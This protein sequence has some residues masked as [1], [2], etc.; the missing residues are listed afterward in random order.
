MTSPSVRDSVICGLKITHDG[1]C[2]VVDHGSLAMSFEVEKHDNNRRHAAME[3]LAYVPHMLHDA[4]YSLDDID[5]FVIDGW[6]GASL[7]AVTVKRDGKDRLSRRE[8]EV[9]RLVAFG[10]TNREIA[11]RIDVSV[12]TVETY[13]YG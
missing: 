6:G 10:Y 12:K 5:L 9:L 7:G 3:N 8:R 13:R 2:A 1:G 11:E 4:G